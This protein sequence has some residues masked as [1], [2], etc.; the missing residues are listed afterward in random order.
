MHEMHHTDA[1]ILGGTDAREAD[2][3]LWL[4]TKELG[5][6]R[7]VAKSARKETSKLR[8]ALQDFTRARVSLVRGRDVWRITGAEQIGEAGPMQ[9]DDLAV[10]GRVSALVARMAPSGEERTGLFEICDA[11][12]TCVR[13]A[14][15]PQ[16]KEL[17]EI[18]TVARILNILGYMPRSLIYQ[19]ALADT[20]IGAEVLGIVKEHRRIFLKD[21]NRGISESQL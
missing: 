16:E 21:I 6:L 19:T 2:R 14:E 11:C 17:I 20:H 8:Y 18:L 13:F 9:A 3:L 12:R 7:A 15:T 10:Y 5:L 1:I 4:L